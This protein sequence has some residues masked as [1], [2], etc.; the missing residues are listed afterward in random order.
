M[1]PITIRIAG[2]GDCFPGSFIVEQD[3]RMAPGMT[4]DEM[5]G[6]IAALTLDAG[7]VWERIALHGGGR[8]G[9]YRME[10]PE[11]SKAWL[12]RHS[13]PPRG[14]EG[15]DIRFITIDEGGGP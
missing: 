2:E 9:L 3:G 6:Q 5:L 12:E 13:A 14:D 11:E 15:K 10:T 1:K 8:G 4:W 7:R